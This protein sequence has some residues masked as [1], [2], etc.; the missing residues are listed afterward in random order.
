MTEFE[1][2]VSIENKKRE[3]KEKNKLDPEKEKQEWF[4]YTKS[5]FDSIR[6][7]LA[8]HI[9]D[10]SIEYKSSTIEMYEEL[11]GKYEIE[12]HDIIIGNKTI[13][14]IPIGTILLGAKGRVDMKLGSRICRLVLVNKDQ[15]EPRINFSISINGIPE[16]KK[17]EIKTP[18]SI[19][20]EW[21][22]STLPP[23]IQY[24]PL[25]EESFKDALMEIASGR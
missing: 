10:G 18:E 11:L 16:T 12:K 19:E 14:L 22:I 4:Q 13:E 21:K 20:W 23:T 17:E 1:Q 24:F 8:S 2:F 5:L 7:Y 3:E 9:K 15:T 6:D 25:N